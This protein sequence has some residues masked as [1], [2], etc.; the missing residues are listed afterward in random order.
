[1]ADKND[2]LIIQVAADT[3]AMR[4][5]W[6]KVESEVTGLS[7]RVNR[8]FYSMGRQI[9][10]TF[11]G[12]GQNMMRNL[13]GPLAGVAGVMATREV[14]QYADAWTV[15]GN[16]LAAAGEV[17]G[18]Q[19]RSLADLNEIANSTRSGIA[20]TADLYAKLLRS[21][22]G[23]AQSELE[24]AKATEVVNKAFKAGGAAASEQAAG[25]MQLAQGLGSGMLQGD[26]LRSV[27]ENAPLLA[28]AIADYFKTSIAGLKELGSEGKLTSDAIF[29]AILA[30]QPQVEAAFSR[31]NATIED[32]ITRVRNALTEYIGGA[33][34]SAGATA[35]LNA[36][37]NALADDFDKFADAGL[38]LAAVIAGALVGRSITGM[39]ASLGVAGKG[40]AGFIRLLAEARAGTGSL[41]TAFAT[42]GAAAGPLAVIIGGG[43]MLGLQHIVSENA[44]ITSSIDSI[45]ER[46]TALGHAGKAAA[47]GID[48]AAEKSEKLAKAEERRLAAAARENLD[49]LRYGTAQG[50]FMAPFTSNRDLA[51]LDAIADRAND[52]RNAFAGDSDK[53]AY[54]AVKQFAEGLRDGG[55]TAEE[56]RAKM[57]EIRETDVSQ[58][59]ADLALA[60]DEV[61]RKWGANAAQANL[62]GPEET[63]EVRR[64]TQQL[65]EALQL[66][67]DVAGNRAGVSPEFLSGLQDLIDKV[68]EGEVEAEELK[69]ELSRLA[70][71]D[72]TFAEFKSGL[73]GVISLLETAWQKAVDA[74]AAMDAIG[75]SNTAADNL[76]TFREAD[77][78]SMK[79]IL[80]GQEWVREQERRLA[81]TRQQRDLEDEIVRLTKEAGDGKYV[82]PAEIERIAKANLAWKEA[83]K[84]GGGGSKSDAQTFRERLADQQISVALLSK[85]AALMGT[86]NPLA[87][88]YET[89]LEAWRMQQELLNEARKAGLADD[90]AVIAGIQQ[91]VEAWK[92]GTDAIASMTEAQDLMR[93][94]MQD[95]D[96]AARSAL[97][98]IIDGFMEGK[99]AGEI[100]SNVLKDLSKQLMRIGMNMLLGSI[101]PGGG[102]IS[103]LLGGGPKLFAKGGI[104]NKPAIFGEAGPEA[105]VPLPDGRRIPVDL[106]MPAIPRAA[107]SNQ[108][109]ELTVHIVSDDEKFSAYVMDKAGRVVAQ[110]APSIVKTSVGASPA[111]TAER[112]L[113]YGAG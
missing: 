111:A 1:M 33:D 106:R 67:L 34:Q 35:A 23:V 21:T 56:V 4:K 74:K 72:G 38:K 63:E 80:A 40:V 58:P 78:N 22:K 47:E 57:L 37:L 17:A 65:R 97:D 108:P 5:A 55:K 87:K 86:L 112:Q 11:A 85:E 103:G 6:T 59:V 15:A 51:S 10:R 42:L 99:D 16:K 36:G 96:S 89:T 91:T 12:I 2:D 24:V 26:E 88:D 76:R 75:S 92:A 94:S 53:S 98:S 100:F 44:R 102:I 113:R 3:A 60:L 66:Q 25:I 19:A 110:A 61:A 90:P 81:L 32:G 8:R 101:F 52:I 62:I 48:A 109:Q 68:D 83:N 104:S 41:A 105:A 18:M 77:A 50:S 46:M 82:D 45:T 107:N 20:E 73:S 29:K 64:Y 79:P 27:R 71:I 9:D 30:A 14:M 31:T 93:Q 43:A 39:V 95:L 70:G 84:G 54:A 13:T 49:A 69:A 7:A 28:Q